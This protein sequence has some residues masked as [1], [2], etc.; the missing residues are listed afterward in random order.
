MVSSFP[1]L[2]AAQ[3]AALIQH[4]ETAGFSGFTLAGDPKSIGRALAERAKN[5]HLGGRPFQIGLISGASTGPSV[6]GALT[7]A[8]AISWRTPFQSDPGLR[9]AI[10]EGKIRFFDMHLSAVPLHLR[11]GFLGKLDWAVIEAAAVYP[12]GR[13]VPTTSVGASPTLCS[14]AR[15]V[16]IELNRFHPPEL[17]GFHDIYESAP[18][19][20]RLPIPLNDCRGRIGTP[21]IQIDPEKIAGIVESNNPDEIP[22]FSESSEVTEQIGVHVADFLSREWKAG[23]IPREFLPL[24]SGIGNIANAVFG[25][26]GRHPGIPAFEMFTEVIQD[27]VIGLI[28]EDKIRF[29]TGTSLRV[30]PHVLREIQR[31][32]AFFKSRLLLRPQEITN[33]P[34]MIQRLGL[35]AINTALEVDLFGN[36]NSTHVMGRNMMNGIGGSGDFTR[37]AYISIFTCPSTAKNGCISTIVPLVSHTDHSEHS[38]N[39]VITE[40]GIADLRGKTPSER[41]QLLVNHCAHPDFQEELQGYLRQMSRS[42]TPQNLANAYAMHLQFQKTGHMRGVEWPA[43]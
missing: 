25:A 20:H 14:Q 19:P 34:E 36:I 17:E 28:R 11:Y 42:H 1:L 22:A 24:Q 39:V 8:A 43:L 35:I 4:G 30:S 23:K 33:S 26:L 27:C 21:C 6:D 3:A 40:Q 38:V 13:I 16:I 29:A 32:L 9:R 18:P 7:Q 12:D 5:E 37:N 2:S 15:R 10:N 41:A 31:D